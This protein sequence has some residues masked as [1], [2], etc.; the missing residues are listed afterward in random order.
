MTKSKAERLTGLTI[1]GGKTRQG[2]C[3]AAWEGDSCVSVLTGSHESETVQRLVEDVLRRRAKQV[4]AAQNWRC[5]ECGRVEEL[6]SHHIV[7]R[8]KGGGHKLSNLRALCPNCHDL[9]HRRG[10]SR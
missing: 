6:Q 3:Y 9:Q 2:Y 10:R 5:D 8:S 7:F 4:F 1:H